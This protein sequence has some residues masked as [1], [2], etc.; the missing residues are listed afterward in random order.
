MPISARII[1][2]QRGQVSRPLL[3]GTRA[4]HSATVRRPPSPASWSA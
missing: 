4:G 1:Q 2:H 3:P